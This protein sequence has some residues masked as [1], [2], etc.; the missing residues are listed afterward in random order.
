M[1]FLARR[2]H[3]FAELEQ[4]L[5]QRHPDDDPELIRE[6]LEQLRTESLLSD[7]RFLESFIHYRMGAGMGPI[8]IAY[9]L[10]AKGV[11]DSDI[12]GGLG[13]YQ[14]SDWLESALKQL[15]RRFPGRPVDMKARQKAWRFLQQ[16]GFDADVV[17]RAVDTAW[18]SDN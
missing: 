18:T 4:K 6:V 7:E 17:A 9:E 2:E 16:R 5:G 3:T 10:R 12:N 14:R 15:R 11:S 8:K 1:D 13:L